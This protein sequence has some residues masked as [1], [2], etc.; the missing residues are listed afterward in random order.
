VK[1]QCTNVNSRGEGDSKCVGGLHEFPSYQDAQSNRNS[2]K[3]IGC[4]AH[5]GVGQTLLVDPCMVPLCKVGMG[6]CV[7]CTQ[8]A[9]MMGDGPVQE[10]EQACTCWRD[11]EMGIE[12]MEARNNAAHHTYDVLR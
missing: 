1:Q 9:C 6:L 7:E 11:G 5:P 4:Q 2:K 8:R 12:E 10:L 3:G